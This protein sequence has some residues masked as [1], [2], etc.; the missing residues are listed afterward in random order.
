MPWA[1]AADGGKTIGRK[2]K[3]AGIATAGAFTRIARRFAG[4]F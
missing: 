4:S 2:S 3:E 1:S